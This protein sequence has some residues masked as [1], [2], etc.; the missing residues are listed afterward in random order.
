MEIAIT[1][2]TAYAAAKAVAVVLDNNRHPDFITIVTVFNNLFNHL[3]GE[4]LIQESR[5]GGYKVTRVVSID[6][7]GETLQLDYQSI[8]TIRWD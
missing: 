3:Y 7:E 4:L 5:G 2:Y 8:D 1:I 6:A